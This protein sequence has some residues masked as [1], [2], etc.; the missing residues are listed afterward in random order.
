LRGYISLFGF[1]DAFYRQ[2]SS[3]EATNRWN[4]MLNLGKWG[5]Y[6]K[7]YQEKGSGVQIGALNVGP[8]FAKAVCDAMSVNVITDALASRLTAVT[9]V[10]TKKTGDVDVLADWKTSGPDF[11]VN[12]KRFCFSG[13]ALHLGDFSIG[14]GKWM[15]MWGGDTYQ[16]RFKECIMYRSQD[17]TGE[18][19]SWRSKTMTIATVTMKIQ[20]GSWYVLTVDLGG[21]VDVS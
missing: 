10:T 13:A 21:S 9:S 8:E 2:Y 7:F 17:I 18:W 12:L 11:Y 4:W 3:T 14:A 19:T 1:T 15:R 6:Q 16:L 5:D 20:E